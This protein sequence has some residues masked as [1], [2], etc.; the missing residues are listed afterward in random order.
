MRSNEMF[1]LLAVSQAILAQH[2]L[3]VK[4]LSTCGGVAGW[5]SGPTPRAAGV[6]PAACINKHPASA[7]L[8]PKLTAVHSA[9]RCRT[10]L[11]PT[12]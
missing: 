10:Q 9:Q 6:K 11:L 1:L 3:L 7:Q 5:L 2:Y 8:Q 12:R 4:L